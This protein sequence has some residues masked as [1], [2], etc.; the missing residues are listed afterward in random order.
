MKQRTL[1]M[2]LQD[3]KGTMEVI[4]NQADYGIIKVQFTVSIDDK[5]KKAEKLDV[6]YENR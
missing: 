5:N 2:K 1:P 6:S 4:F 3:P